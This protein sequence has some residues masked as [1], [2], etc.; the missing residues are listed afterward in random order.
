VFSEGKGEYSGIVQWQDSGL[1]N[2]GWFG[3]ESPSRSQLMSGCSRAVR[4]CVASAEIAGSTPAS[5]SMILIHECVFA[6]VAERAMHLI[7]NEDN[8][9]SIPA[10]SSGMQ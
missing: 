2:R 9:G 7:R 5:R 6:G 10:A 1:W 8:A 3:F 4:R